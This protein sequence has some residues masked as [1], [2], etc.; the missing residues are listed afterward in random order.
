MFQIWAGDDC[1]SAAGEPARHRQCIT[2]LDD[3][4]ALKQSPLTSTTQ[5][6]PNH[7]F[8]NN[9]SKLWDPIHF[10]QRKTFLPL[11]HVLQHVPYHRRS[12]FGQPQE[13]EISILLVAI[14]PGENLFRVYVVPGDRPHPIPTWCR[15]KITSKTTSLPKTP[16]A[17]PWRPGFL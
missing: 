11:R 5:P 15:N 6:N 2:R 8:R 12:R 16:R 14:A 7:L 17:T 13:T 3:C 10:V 4:T 9:L 1:A